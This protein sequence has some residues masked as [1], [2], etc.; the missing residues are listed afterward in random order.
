MAEKRDYY[1][2]LGV[3]KTASDDEIK[4]AYRSLAKKYHP[5][6]NPGDKDAEAKF[7]EINEAYSVLS[8]ADERRKYD[9][10]GHAAFDP[11]AGAG[12]GGFG[13][14]GFGDF[15]VDLGDIFGSF[16]GG[17]FG[18][19]SSS[20][21]SRNA[22]QRGDDIG[23]N[24]TIT[25]E[26]AAF[27]CKKEITY[28]RIENCSDCGGSGA[29]K[30]TT[31]ETCP[32]CHGTGSVRVSQSTA[33]GTMQTVRPCSACRGKGKIIKT[34]CPTCKGAGS[35]KKQKRIEFN[36]PA[37]IADGE[38][39][40]LRGQGCV[41]ENGGPAGDL[42][43]MVSVKPHNFF[44]RRANNLYCEIPITFVEATL[45]GKVEVPTLEGK[46]EFSVPEGTQTGTV[47]CLKGKGIQ[48]TN[49]GS[50]GNLY[51]T[52]NVEVPKNLTQK[53]KEALMAFGDSCDIKNYSKKKSFFDKF[54]KK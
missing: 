24:L 53:Q 52:V 9:Q 50:R 14:G 51:V 23:Y 44:E 35:I 16:F 33:F 42:I 17:G 11:S 20:R 54:I 37:G 10:Y 8:N 5:D 48:S 19:G 6:A 4:K 18:G 36:I 26:E 45:G 40:L 32:T 1:E 12:Y 2:V 15:N 47:F 7:K 46:S 38:R 27:G 3:S 21:S 25:F 28:S 13:S 39:V 29:A 22:P 30:G 43:I 49:G 34:P 31:A 41:G